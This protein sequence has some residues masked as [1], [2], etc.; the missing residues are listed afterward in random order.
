MTDEESLVI[1]S[2]QGAIINCGLTETY[3]SSGHTIGVGFLIPGGGRVYKDRYRVQYRFD[4]EQASSIYLEKMR[5]GDGLFFRTESQ[6]YID[7]W[8]ED[9][10]LYEIGIERLAEQTNFIKKMI[11]K[12]RLLIRMPTGS[13]STVDMTVSLIGLS[14]HLTPNLEYCGLK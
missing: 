8:G 11:A 12:N 2:D 10:V 14:K 4:K 1:I 3:S 5:S 7:H 13:G 9:S 6:E